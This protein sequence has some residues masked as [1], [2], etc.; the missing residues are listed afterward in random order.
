[1]RTTR[2]VLGVGALVLIV[3]CAVGVSV[4]LQQSPEQSPRVTVD[5]DGTI[6]I[7]AHEVSLTSYMSEEAI[8]SC[9]DRKVYSATIQFPHDI[10][11]A[12]VATDRAFCPLLERD[13]DFYSV[14]IEEKLTVWSFAR[15][16]PKTVPLLSHE[17]WV[18]AGTWA[19]RSWAKVS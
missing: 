2:D 15:I 12:R 11:K 10:A 17:F 19:R 14:I 18:D 9:I 4:N 6:N 5:P 3:Y 16:P 7:L 13:K 1:M 8:W